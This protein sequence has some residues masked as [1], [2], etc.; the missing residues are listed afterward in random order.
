MSK[1]DPLGEYLAKQTTSPITLTFKQVEDVLGFPLPQSAYNHR[2]WWANGAS[3]ANIWLSRG[4]RTE[5][6][7]MG[8]NQVTFRRYSTGV[9]A[10]KTAEPKQTAPKLR[11]NFQNDSENAAAKTATPKRMEPEQSADSEGEEDI[12]AITNRE[13]VGKVMDLLRE[14]LA[15]FVERKAKEAMHA[16]KIDIRQVRNYRTPSELNKKSFLEWDVSALL[17]VMLNNWERV[18]FSLKLRHTERILVKELRDYRN[19]WAHQGTFSND[20]VYRIL[21]ATNVLLD[22][23]QAPQAKKIEQFKDELC[24]SPFKGHERGERIS[25]PE[26]PPAES[27]LERATGPER[28]ELERP[29]TSQHSNRRNKYDRLGEYLDKRGESPITMKFSQINEVLGFRLASSAYKHQAW[30]SNSTS[31]SQAN[32]WLSRGWRTENVDIGGCQVAF[33]RGK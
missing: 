23:M 30:W 8:G 19:K 24:R 33:R 21:V 1:Y 10:A 5:K 4:W 31:Q 9:A 27:A 16:C 25:A 17:G 29:G 12:M 20:E 11:V 22:A 32:A 14:A 15:P 26:R 7:D 6:V 3:Q 13:R 18:F 28:A 2:P